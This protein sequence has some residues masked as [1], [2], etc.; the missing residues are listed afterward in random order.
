MGKQLML[1]PIT[2]MILL[3]VSGCS[4]SPQTN[5]TMTDHTHPA[6]AAVSHV[7]VKSESSTSGLKT[8][9][10]PG[11]GISQPNQKTKQGSPSSTRD[12]LLSYSQ[13]VGLIHSKGYTVDENKPNANVQ[14]ATGDTLSA[15][16]AT[17]TDSQDGYNQFV[18]FFLNGE[19]LGT[20]T[21]KPSIEI[22]RV[23][24]DR[25]S[26]AVTYSVYTKNDS[27]ADPTGKPITIT[28]TWNGSRLIPNK[29]YPKQ[30]QNQ[31]TMSVQSQHL[32]RGASLFHQVFKTSNHSPE[33]F[34]TPSIGFK[35]TNLG[36]GMNN[37][38]YQFSKT[39][40]GGETWIAMSRDHFSNVIG[41]SFLNEKVGFL[42]NNSPAYAVTPNLYMTQNG[43]VSWKKEDLP[44]PLTYKNV[45]RFSDFP[46]FFSNKIGFI[47]IYGISMHSSTSKHFLYMLVST[48]SGN[49]WTPYTQFHGAGLTWT[50]N[51]NSLSVTHGTKTINI[52]DLFGI[53]RVTS[54]GF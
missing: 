22:T 6:T 1:I 47:P 18:F 35:M 34:L 19:Y 8:S 37:F 21:A 14:T 53:W 7:I 25:Q 17:A 51:K 3:T 26:V 10:L 12:S 43:G 46:I 23:E 24:P 20:D 38:E 5:R 54:V 49:T 9:S 40:N 33:V 28:Y 44:I 13:E 45:Y 16:I 36:G 29:A 11:S 31:D 27:F 32:T 48:N 42:L 4:T 30:F 15:W 39:T 52:E 2:G 41:I 50:T